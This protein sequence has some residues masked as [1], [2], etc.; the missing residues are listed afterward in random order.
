MAVAAAWATRLIT[1]SL[2]MVIP[3]VGGYWLDQYLGTV[4]LFT[5]LGFGLGLTLGIMHLIRMTQSDGDGPADQ[6]R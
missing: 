1:V 6:V 2:E 3:G 4:V 5:L